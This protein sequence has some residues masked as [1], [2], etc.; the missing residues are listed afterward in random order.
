MGDGGFLSGGKTARAEDNHSPPS[1][2]EVKKM[3]I[4]ISI[5]PYVFMA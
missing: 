1:H 4:Y 3:W 5:P 2:A